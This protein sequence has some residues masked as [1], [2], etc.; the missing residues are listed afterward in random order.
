MNPIVFQC[1]VLAMLLYIMSHVG[2]KK[3][4]LLDLGMALAALGFIVRAIVV[5]FSS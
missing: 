2:P 5:L 1:T 4:P 3:H